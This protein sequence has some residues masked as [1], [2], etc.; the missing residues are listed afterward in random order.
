MSPT[1]LKLLALSKIYEIYNNPKSLL[2]LL[3]K[4][5]IQSKVLKVNA[6]SKLGTRRL[7]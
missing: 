6:E 1:S 5:N 3:T 7:L 2:K 4:Q